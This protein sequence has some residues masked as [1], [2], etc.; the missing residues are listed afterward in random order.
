MRKYLTSYDFSRLVRKFKLNT[1]ETRALLIDQ[2]V[3][4]PDYN[5]NELGQ[6]IGK[7]RLKSICR[8]LK[9]PVTGSKEKLWEQIVTILN[10]KEGK[11]EKKP[12]LS[13]ASISGFMNKFMKKESIKEIV[14]EFPIKQTGTKEQLID[15]LLADPDFELHDVFY[16][17]D[18]WDLQEISQKL[19]VHS[20]GNKE[21]LWHGI[22]QKLETEEPE[23]KKV[24]EPSHDSPDRNLVQI[25][26]EWVPTKRHRSEG[27][28]QTELRS[29]LEYKYQFNVKE[30]AGETQVDILVENEKPIELKKNPNRGDFDRLSGQIERHIEKYGKLI[31][32]ICQL[33][34]RDL[35]N[36]YKS[37]F[38]ERFSSDQLIWIVK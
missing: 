18:L 10:L 29:L 7:D 28:Y 11:E 14:N 4:N 15:R 1:G 25:I 37:R 22:L 17:F 21:E 9:L 24:T 27:E 6:V 8:F 3:T 13:K 35:Y 34:H 12:S 2:I 26:Q 23:L 16:G 36:E 30:E 33:Q 38:E 19:R 5:L 20:S 31:I 32:V